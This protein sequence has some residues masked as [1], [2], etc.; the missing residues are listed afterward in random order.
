[1]RAVRAT[2]GRQGRALAQLQEQRPADDPL[3]VWVTLPVG[4]D[5][6]DADA[7]E[8]VA[9]MLTTGV[10]LAGVN[11]MTMNRGEGTTAGQDPVEAATAAARAAQVQVEEL[12]AQA[13][14]AETVIALEAR[15]VVMELEAARQPRRWPAQAPMPSL[16][17]MPR[18]ACRWFRHDPLRSQAGCASHR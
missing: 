12:Y 6:L 16:H 3:E 2:H 7:R 13:G 18:R 1:M 14:V 10:D 9:Q 15:P 11:L 17:R 8:V 4:V 5:G